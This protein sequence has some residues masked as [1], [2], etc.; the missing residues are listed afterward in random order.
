MEPGEWNTS[1]IGAGTGLGRDTEGVGNVQQAVGDIGWLF[2]FCLRLCLGFGLGLFRSAANHLLDDGADGWG[3]RAVFRDLL[4]DQFV[5]FGSRVPQHFVAGFGRGRRA[6]FEEFGDFGEVGARRNADHRG[7]SH[8]GFFETAIGLFAFE[9]L[10]GAVLRAFVH[11]DVAVETGDLLGLFGIG[12]VFDG[13]GFEFAQESGSA[14]QAATCVDQAIDEESL[15]GALGPALGRG[16][17]SNGSELSFL[18]VG[19]SDDILSSESVGDGVLGDGGLS[20]F[21]ARTGTMLRILNVGSMF[22]IRKHKELPLEAT[23]ARRYW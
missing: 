6:A 7:E 18:I 23:L 1:E 9:G 15:G 12:G 14:Q 10:E 2:L 3:D 11:L 22:V 21:G 8:R 16:L 17:G 4:G 20:S 5:G 13:A 19:A